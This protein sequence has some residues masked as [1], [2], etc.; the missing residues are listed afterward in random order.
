MRAVRENQRRV[1]RRPRR[2]IIA[3]I[4]TFARA[5]QVSCRTLLCCHLRGG[6]QAVD[7]GYIHPEE[8]VVFLATGNGL[9][10][11][12]RRKPPSVVAY[13]PNPHSTL[14]VMR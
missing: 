5:S 7:L 8:R 14:F 11:V 9:K 2:D 1:C 13:V 10:D 6:K 3:A 4:Q 12:R